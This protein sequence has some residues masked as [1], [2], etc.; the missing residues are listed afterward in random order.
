MPASYFKKT[1]RL[2]FRHWSAEDLPLAC[3]LWKDPQVS[4]FLGGPFS[5]EQV[6]ARL[7]K[8]IQTQADCGTQYWPVFLLQTGDFVGCAGLRPYDLWRGV[9]ELGAH[10]RP[11]YWRRG[12]AEEA[13]RAAIDF[14]FSNLGAT[15]V[16][17]GHHPENESSRRLLVKLGFKYT[18]DELYAPTGEMHP[19]YLLGRT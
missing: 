9:F 7:R 8:E 1:E 14:A 19:S 16:F 13:A 17:A 3:L 11:Q 2:G 4:R 18:H 6:V 15:A 5:D 12:L 10:L